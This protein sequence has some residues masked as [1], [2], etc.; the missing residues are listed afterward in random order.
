INLSSDS[1]TICG[2]SSTRDCAPPGLVSSSSALH[3]S[4][5]NGP[6]PN[7]PV[8]L[9]GKPPVKPRSCSRSGTTSRSRRSPVSP[10]YSPTVLLRQP[11]RASNPLCSRFSTPWDGRLHLLVSPR[12]L[13]QPDWPR[14]LSPKK[15]TPL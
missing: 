5:N 2:R 1:V 15:E 9:L 11:S 3:S 4:R 7:S 13:T 6:R 14:S 8:S 10:Q 12:H